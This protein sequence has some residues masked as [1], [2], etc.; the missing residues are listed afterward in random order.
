MKTR[1]DNSTR[2]YCIQLFYTYFLHLPNPTVQPRDKK[3]YT[4][5]NPQ[6]LQLAPPTCMHSSPPHLHMKLRFPLSCLQESLEASGARAGP[7][8]L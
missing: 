2:T 8:G 3:L 1:Q 5:H 4:L 6:A 7:L